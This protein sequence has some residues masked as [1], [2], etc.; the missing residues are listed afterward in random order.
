MQVRLPYGQAEAGPH[1]GPDGLGRPWIGAAVDQHQAVRP[2]GVGRPPHRTQISRVLHS[3]QHHIPP[4]GQP[5]RQGQVRGPAEKQ[6]ALGR[7]GGRQTPEQVGGDLHPPD[8]GGQLRQACPL[9]RHHGR[10]GSPPFQGLGEQLWPVADEL[11]R[12]PAGGAGAAELTDVGRQ[13]IL[14]ARDPFHGHPPHRSWS[15]LMSSFRPS[16]TTTSPERRA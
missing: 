3:I 10:N 2:K 12:R 8:G 7:L 5:F 11:P 14:S 4:A 13:F 16:V 9:L 15:R 6:H 1:S